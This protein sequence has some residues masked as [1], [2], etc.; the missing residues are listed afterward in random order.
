MSSYRCDRLG[1]YKRVT[2][3]FHFGWFMHACAHW[4]NMQIWFHNIIIL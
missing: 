2:M 3:G 1:G 4:A